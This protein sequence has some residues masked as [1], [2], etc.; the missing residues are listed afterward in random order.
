VS[1]TRGSS[2]EALRASCRCIVECAH[3]PK[4]ASAVQW[5]RAAFG[6]LQFALAERNGL[7]DAAKLVQP[8][9]GAMKTRF[10]QFAI[11]DRFSQRYAMPVSFERRRKISGPRAAVADADVIHTGALQVSG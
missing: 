10:Q 1:S 5:I 8:Q 11:A 9:G 6:E 4:S 7:V 2:S 3:Q